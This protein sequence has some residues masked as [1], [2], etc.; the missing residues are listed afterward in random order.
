MNDLDLRAALHRDADLVG[1]PSPD[2]LDQLVSRRSHQRRQRAGVLTAVLAVVVIGAS[3]PVGQTLLTRGDGAPA[4]QTTVDQTPSVT[5]ENPAP[6]PDVAETPAV[7]PSETPSVT[8]EPEVA[9]DLPAP[10]CPDPATLL[11]IWPEPPAPGAQLQPSSMQ[12]LCSGEWA[13]TVFIQSGVDQ[14]I[15]WG[16]SVP[17]LFRFVDGA[18]TPDNRF[19]RCDAGAIPDDIWELVCNAG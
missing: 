2:L 1:E 7:T 9:E 6:A 11:S 3:I 17:A 16:N 12:T 5:P 18:W 14:G 8:T 4:D 10:D 19:E 13:F 15:E